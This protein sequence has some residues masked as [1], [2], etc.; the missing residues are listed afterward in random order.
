MEKTIETLF[1]SWSFTDAVLTQRKI[2]SLEKLFTS[3]DEIISRSVK[4]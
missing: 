2:F 1:L 4:P 3:A